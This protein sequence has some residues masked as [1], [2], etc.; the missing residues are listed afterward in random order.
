[1]ETVRIV[2]EIIAAL[3]LLNVWLLRLSKATP[4]RGGEARSMREE[5]A[6]YGLPF[7]FMGL[8]GVLKVAIALAFLV[9][10]WVPALVQP[11]AMLLGILMLGA[12]LMH[13]KVKDPIKKAVPSIGMLAM[14]AV[15]AFL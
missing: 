8:I 5:F 1:M 7:W 6:V 14:A 11:A 9:G 12:F 10:I 4:Y 13:L 15:I 2:L 3:G